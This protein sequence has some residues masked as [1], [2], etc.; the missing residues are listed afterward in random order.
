MIKGYRVMLHPNNKQNS[1]LWRYAKAAQFAYDW[2]LD[3]EKEQYEKGLKFLSDSKLRKEFTLLKTLPEYKWLADIDCDVT[4]QA[5]KDAVKAYK[6]FFKRLT[7]YPKHKSKRKPKPSFYQDPVKLQVFEQHIKLVL[8]TGKGKGSTRRAKIFNKVK[9]A[10]KGRIPINVKYQNPRV[11][12]DGLHWWISVSVD[13]SDTYQTRSEN[14]VSDGL[15]IDLGV[16]KPATC[17]DGKIISNINK[18]ESLVRLQKRKKHIQRTIAHKYE[19]N[20]KGGR[21]RKTKNIIKSKRRLRK[22]CQRITHMQDEHMKS[23]IKEILSKRPH[24]IGVEDLNVRGLLQNHK[25][26]RVIQEEKFYQ[27]KTVLK[28]HA[29]QLKI[30]V[31]DV[32][33]WYPSS[34][35]CSSCGYKKTDLKLSD[36]LFK[37]PECGLRID[38]DLN[39]AINIRE[40]ARKELAG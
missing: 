34:K 39:A 31:I 21:Y 40:Y 30:P 23:A 28:Q 6:S 27:F 15:G 1:V 9:L 16:A 8:V 29:T 22:L 24:F 35:L 33:R 12:F 3:R 13:V 17:S 5:I 20:K 10:E 4:K 38:R 11:T 7:K 36:R 37:C 19:T 2:T 32:D 25:L 26:A 14:L 18:E